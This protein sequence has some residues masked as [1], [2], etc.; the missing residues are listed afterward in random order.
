MDFISENE[1]AVSVIMPSLNTSRYIYQCLLSVCEQTLRN[2]EILC[3]DAGSSD[4]TIEII[5]ELASRDSRIRLIRSPK[6][7]YGYQIN[8]GIE[9]A[10]GEYI[11]IVETDDYISIDMYKTLYDT[12]LNTRKP[13]IVKTGFYAVTES[14]SETTMEIKKAIHA[15]TG[16]VFPLSAHYEI[17][18]GHP[19]VWAA[20][21]RKAFLMNKSIRMMEVPGAG[22]VDN[23][24]LFQ[25]ICEADRIAWVNEGLYYYRTNSQ[26]SSSVNIDHVI[27]ITRINDI[28][29]YLDRVHPNNRYLESALF[30]R[31]MWSV[32]LVLKDSHLTKE[33]VIRIINMLKRFRISTAC[34]E[35]CKW[36]KKKLNYE[37]NCINE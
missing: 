8:I 36:V 20:I 16:E 31:A 3:I 21:Y 15:E 28:K 19:S 10:R 29:D 26:N 7:S 24:F 13:D 23:P 35:T 33:D 14:V 25:S 27:P 4:G 22:W 9:N 30:Y 12:A 2:I 18:Y 17:L 5:S 32:F 37:R 1:I 34:S 11:G 6:K